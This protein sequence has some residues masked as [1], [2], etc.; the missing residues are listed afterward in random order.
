MTY[1]TYKLAKVA[2]KAIKQTRTS[3]YFVPVGPCA[4]GTTTLLPVISDE[5]IPGSNFSKCFRSV[6]KKT[7]LFVGLN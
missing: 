3:T 5:K 1:C 4:N 6:K 7:K 2:V